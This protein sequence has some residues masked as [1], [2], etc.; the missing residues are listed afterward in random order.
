MKRFGAVK[1]RGFDT[2]RDAG[3]DVVGGD[4]V[5]KVGS[6]GQFAKD[7]ADLERNIKQAHGKDKKVLEHG[8]LVITPQRYVTFY[9]TNF[10]AQLSHFYLRKGFKV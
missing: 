10:P 2:I 4:H 8:Q 1:A 9:F 3:C 6:A 7:D 5:N